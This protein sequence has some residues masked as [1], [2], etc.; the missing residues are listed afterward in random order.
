[1]PPC[2][3]LNLAHC[4]HDYH[5]AIVQRIRKLNKEKGFAVAVMVRAKG[6]RAVG[7]GLC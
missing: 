2:R 4:S 5:R 3:R 7:H 1:V 6:W